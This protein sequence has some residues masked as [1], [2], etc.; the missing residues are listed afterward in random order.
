MSMGGARTL[1]VDQDIR[2]RFEWLTPRE[3]EV[4]LL[5][6]EGVTN[7]TAAATLG[8]SRRTIETH[9][10]N[11]LEKLRTNS[12]AELRDLCVRYGISNS[13]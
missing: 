8:L 9:R 2:Q 10:G 11:I 13:P 1:D 4:M 7:A 12:N 5:L 3:R 6:I